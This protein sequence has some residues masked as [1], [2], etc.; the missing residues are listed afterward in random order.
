MKRMGH[1][2]A[3]EE[4]EEYEHFVDLNSLKVVNNVV[5]EN[6]EFLLVSKSSDILK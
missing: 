1:V 6:Y 5:G 4:L 2:Y 3:N